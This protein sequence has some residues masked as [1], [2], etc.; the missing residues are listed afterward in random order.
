MKRQQAGF[1]L[2]E[3]AIVLV[4][5]GLLLGGVLKGQ[6]MITSSKVRQVIN[7]MKAVQTTFYAYQDRYRAVPGDDILASTRFAGAQSGGGN[8]I[9]AGL[10]QTS[11]SVLS[12]ATESE[13]F[14][15]HARAAGFM[16]GTPTSGLPPTSALGGR[17]GVQNNAYGLVGPVVCTSLESQYAIS[18]DAN[19]DD[20]VATT[21]DVRAGAAGLT[22]N[23]ATGA[24]PAVAYAAPVAASPYVVICKKL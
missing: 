2:V 23:L 1:T 8:G 16:Q 21:G 15:Q 22:L 14:W 10:Y 7:D 5:I 13:N 19:L 17:I 9:I 18:I 20:G 12:A 24:G 6:E 3:I 4:I 11:G